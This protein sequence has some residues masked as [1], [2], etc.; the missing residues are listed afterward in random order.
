LIGLDLD[1]DGSA[2]VDFL[3]REGYGWADYHLSADKAY[4]FPNTGVQLLALIDANGR[5]VY[6]HDGA[7]DD[8]GLVNAIKELAPAYSAALNDVE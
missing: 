2:A 7:D 8:V 3:K 5:F 6:Y 1:S 4:G